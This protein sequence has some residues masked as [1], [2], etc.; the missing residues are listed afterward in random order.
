VRFGRASRILVPEAP[1]LAAQRPPDPILQA[2]DAYAAGRYD[3]A[4]AQIRAVRNG[5]DLLD[6]LKDDTPKWIDAASP[7]MRERRRRVAAALALEAV[8]VNFARAVIPLGTGGRDLV[9]GAPPHARRA[10]S[11]ACDA[12]PVDRRSIECVHL[13]YER[14]TVLG[15]VAAY[16]N[17]RRVDLE[18]MELK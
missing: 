8:H 11:R 16:A 4:L 3:E 15:T 6:G 18:S 9:R 5:D 1:R 13:G 10:R 14:A 12:P 2:L 7:E 17:F